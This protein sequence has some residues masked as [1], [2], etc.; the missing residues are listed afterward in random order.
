MAKATETTMTTHPIH[1]RY[2][3]VGFA[4]F[5][6]RLLAQ[7]LLAPAL[8]S[9]IR[10]TGTSKEK[11]QETERWIRESSD[12]VSLSEDLKK[13]PLKFV[14]TFILLLILVSEVAYARTL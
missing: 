2:P 13:N 10:F 1:R 5:A 4:T 8:K 7:N 12:G 3:A 11:W 9:M 14:P 6:R